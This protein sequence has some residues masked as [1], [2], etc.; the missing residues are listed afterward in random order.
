[1]VIA[2]RRR[3]QSRCGDRSR[4]SDGMDVVSRSRDVVIAVVEDSEQTE[5][6]QRERDTRKVGI[7][8]Y[9]KYICSQC[10]LPSLYSIL[11][12]TF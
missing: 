4:L 12:R 1:M 5:R 7:G 11:H 6:E 2:V 9:E 3:R 10:S 8:E